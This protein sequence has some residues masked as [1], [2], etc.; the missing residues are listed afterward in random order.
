M[1]VSAGCADSAAP[2]GVVTATEASVATASAVM[3]TRLKV[4]PFPSKGESPE[5]LSTSVTGGSVPAKVPTNG[6]SRSRQTGQPVNH[7][8]GRA[9]RVRI[10][11]MIYYVRIRTA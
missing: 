1:I 10:P 2:A 9:R 3:R 7:L 11:I 5:T 4:S 6:G 8:G